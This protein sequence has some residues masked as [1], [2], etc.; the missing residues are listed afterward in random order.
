MSLDSRAALFVMLGQTASRIVAQI[1]EL[2]PKE[3]LLLSSSYDLAPLLPYH[4]RRAT[5]AA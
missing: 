1:E 3:S 5:A 4:V 2:V